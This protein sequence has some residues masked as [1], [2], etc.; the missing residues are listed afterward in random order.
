[1]KVKYNLL[2]TAVALTFLFYS[3]SSTSTQLINGALAP[4]IAAPDTN[5][6]IIALSSLRGN[7]VL[8]DFWASWCAPCRKSNPKLVAIYDKYKKVKFKDAQGFKMYSVSADTKRDKWLQ[9]IKKD[10]LHWREHV[11]DLNGWESAALDSFK[12]TSIP[13]AF[14]I[15][16]DGM[17]IGKNLSPLDIDKVLSMRLEQ[18]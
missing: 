13:A 12:I 9:A 18:Q 11:S 6:Q 4:E 17:I 1:M 14:L 5:N 10:Q 15:D 8:V 16:Q 3:C 2:L 7:I